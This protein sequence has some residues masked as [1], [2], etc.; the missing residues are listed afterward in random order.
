MLLLLDL[1]R[2]SALKFPSDDDD[3]DDV[4]DDLLPPD[5]FTAGEN[6]DAEVEEGTLVVGPQVVNLLNGVLSVAKFQNIITFL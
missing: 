3:A 1:D 2:T 6:A 4:A 5:D